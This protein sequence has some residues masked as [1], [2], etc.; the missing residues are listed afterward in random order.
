MYTCVEISWDRFQWVRLQLA[1]F[2]PKYP[3]KNP[4]DVEAKLKRLGSEVGILKLNEVYDE[5]YET[6]TQGRASTEEDVKRTFKFVLW[7]QKP[8]VS[9]ELAEA[10]NSGGILR[11]YVDRD[12]ILQICCN[13]VIVEKGD[14]V[15]LAHLS[16]RE[17]L[18]KS[19]RFTDM[20]SDLQ[21]HAQTAESCLAYVTHFYTKFSEIDR[22]EKCFGSYAIL[23]WPVHCEKAAKIR[24]EE[25][26]PQKLFIN[27]LLNEEVGQAFTKWIK[28]LYIAAL[29]YWD[30]ESQRLT[31]APSS[32]PSPVFAASVWGF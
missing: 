18:Q 30:P 21:A 3:F 7:S 14:I 26:S 12:Y 1:T 9:A 16:V 24:R 31:D 29:R 5:I 8:L 19:P 15:Q 23:Y 6:N 13:L 22:H 27:L 25:S 32:P 10:V 4:D 20:Y 11:S 28:A 2:Y 17:Y